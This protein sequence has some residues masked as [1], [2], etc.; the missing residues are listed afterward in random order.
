MSD[1]N[2]IWPYLLTYHN[3]MGFIAQGVFSCRLTWLCIVNSPYTCLSL[4][5]DI[6][7]LSQDVVLIS[8]S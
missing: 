5:I 8:Y 6:D 2:D 4:M 1:Q 3:F 7:G